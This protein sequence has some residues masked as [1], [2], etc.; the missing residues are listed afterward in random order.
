MRLATHQFS[1]CL[2]VFVEFFPATISFCCSF[3]KSGFM[4]YELKIFNPKVQS[5]SLNVT[6]DLNSSQSGSEALGD[7]CVC[8]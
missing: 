6:S 7:T 1:N 2:E 5:S 4:N 8:C 3:L